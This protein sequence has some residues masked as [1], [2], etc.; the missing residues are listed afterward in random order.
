MLVGRIVTPQ[1][2]IDQAADRDKVKA[3][4]RLEL[5]AG[6][7]VNASFSEQDLQPFGSLP[8]RITGE[9]APIPFEGTDAET[10]LKWM[11]VPTLVQPWNMHRCGRPARARSVGS[12]QVIRCDEH[13]NDAA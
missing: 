9:I 12:D 10:C 3:S 2:L 1:E 4:D 13:A 6:K 8:K 5:K 7:L 11:P